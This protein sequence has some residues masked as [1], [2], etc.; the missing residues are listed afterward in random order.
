MSGEANGKYSERIFRE[1]EGHGEKLYQMEITLDRACHSLELLPS[2]FDDLKSAIQELKTSLVVL[3]TRMIIGLFLLLI[4]EA[5]AITGVYI[6][7]GQHEIR[8]GNDSN[9]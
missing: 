2:K 1:I 9:K 4:I 7:S 3:L 6:K 8:A 5:V